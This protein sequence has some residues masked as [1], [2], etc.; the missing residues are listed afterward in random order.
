VVSGTD[1]RYNEDFTFDKMG[2]ITNF[3]RGGL[4]STTGGMSYG[5]IDNLTL[6]HT[7]NQLTKVTEY[8]YGKYLSD[9]IFCPFGYVAV[10]CCGGYAI[11]RRNRV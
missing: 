6:N 8:G 1:D 2:N 4:Q 11:R 9:N 3:A 10:G 7:G 5:T